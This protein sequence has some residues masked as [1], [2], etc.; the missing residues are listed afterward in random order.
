[1]ATK[2]TRNTK[3]A[4]KPAKPGRK[5]AANPFAHVQLPEGFTAITMGEFGDPWD[6]ESDPVI[7]GTVSGDVREIEVPG[8]KRGTTRTARAVTIEAD[9]GRRIDVWESASLKRWF[10]TIADGMAVA[11]VFQGYRDTGRPSPMKVFVGSI[12]DEEAVE[13][14]RPTHKLPPLKAAKPARKAARR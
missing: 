5:T 2:V 4:A 11:V 12:A 6:Y 10:D 8:D 7:Q 9:D 3:T 1:M 14:K 13:R